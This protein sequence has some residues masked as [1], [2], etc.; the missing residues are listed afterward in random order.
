MK[1]ICKKRAGT[2]T[3]QYFWTSKIDGEMKVQGDIIQ[4]V[5][6]ILE[7]RVQVL[8]K[9]VQNKNEDAKNLHPQ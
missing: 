5:L 3:I 8:N 7:D 6:R 9:Q 1:G 2:E 4:T